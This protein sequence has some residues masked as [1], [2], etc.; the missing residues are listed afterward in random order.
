MNRIALTIP[1]EPVA[2]GRPRWAKF[3]IYTPKKTVAYET[4]IQEIFC[5]T[6]P[7]FQPLKGSLCMEINACFTIP[8]SKGKKEKAL[9]IE[10]KI[11]PAKRPDI[12]N[13]AKSVMD[14]LSHFAY[15]DD[16]QIVDLVVAKYYSETPKVDIIIADIPLV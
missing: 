2:K 16:S 3:G 1:G 14:A 13:V 6:Y 11:R 12:E 8:K 4:L 10:G 15:D 7:G 5:M 9:M